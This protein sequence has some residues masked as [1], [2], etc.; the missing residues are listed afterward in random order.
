[1]TDVRMSGPLF[2]GRARIAASEYVQQLK[3]DV[4]DE[5]VELV[6]GQ[7]DVVLRNPTGHYR[8]RI[9]TDRSKRDWRVWDRREVYGPWLEGTG[10]RNK[11]TRFKGYATFRLMTQALDRQVLPIAKRT[12]PRFL[13]RMR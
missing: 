5:G 4:T 13:R 2:D 3:Q 7:L 12:L 8:S 1:M 6:Q 10:E 9:Q 11:T